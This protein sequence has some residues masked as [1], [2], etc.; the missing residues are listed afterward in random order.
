MR[1]EVL[2][3]GDSAQMWYRVGQ[4]QPKP[5]QKNSPV[6]IKFANSVMIGVVMRNDENGWPVKTGT[7]YACSG[8]PIDTVIDV[9]MIKPAAPVTRRDTRAPRSGNSNIKKRRRTEKLKTRTRRRSRAEDNVDTLPKRH[10]K[11]KRRRKRRKRGKP[12]Q[13][14]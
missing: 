4:D 1:L 9:Q 3:S 5:L 13:E 14:L 12:R 7:E 8:S 2:L 11:K 6:F 10:K